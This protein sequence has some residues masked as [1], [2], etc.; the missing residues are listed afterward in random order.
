LLV[1]MALLSFIVIG[2]VS[3]FGQTQRAFMQSLTDVDL[4]ENGRAVMD[5]LVRDLSEAGPANVSNAANFYVEFP[6]PGENIYAPPL[7]QG[8]PG[9]V[10]PPQLRFNYLQPFFF[11]SHPNQAWPDKAWAATGYYVVPDVAGVGVGTLYRY[12]ATNAIPPAQPLPPLPPPSPDYIVSPGC[13]LMTYY[14]NSFVNALISLRT[15]TSP[16]PRAA[17]VST[18]TRIAQGVVHLTARP[19]ATNGFPIVSD[20]NPLMYGY[21][22]FWAS[23]NYNGS[24]VTYAQPILQASNHMNRAYPDG[25]DSC[26]FMSNAVPA[27]VELELGILESHTYQRYQAIVSANPPAG[28]AFLSN[29]VAQVHIFRKRVPIHNVDPSAY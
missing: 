22:A 15:D 7:V 8:L 29:H 23:S 21:T 13:F 5:L 28:A 9:T 17:P 14:P 26:W 3:M 16:V 24:Y 27:Y 10:S 18:V 4:L 11:L 25:Y 1:A 6:Q 12:T 19:F 2:L 20:L